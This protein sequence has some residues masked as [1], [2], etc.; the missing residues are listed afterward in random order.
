MV[1]VQSQ[2]LVLLISATLSFA[3]DIT[4]TNEGSSSTIVWLQNGVVTLDSLSSFHTDT[5]HML[6]LFNRTLQLKWENY[7]PGNVTYSIYVQRKNPSQLNYT[8][9]VPIRGDLNPVLPL[10]SVFEFYCDADNAEER[11]PVQLIITLDDS[12]ATELIDFSFLIGCTACK[13]DCNY[14]NGECINDICNCSNSY[15]GDACQYRRSFTI[16]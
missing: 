1:R 16:M 15:F 13:N 9:S 2:L 7:E 8:L 10:D 12:S 3:F 11:E 4:I 5:S 14:P 6:T